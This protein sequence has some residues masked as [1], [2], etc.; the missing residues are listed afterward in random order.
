MGNEEHKTREDVKELPK[1]KKRERL[2]VPYEG[3]EIADTFGPF[4]NE[5]LAQGMAALIAAHEKVGR[6]SGKSQLNQPHPIPAETV[7]AH[8]DLAVLAS[9]E[10][11]QRFMDIQEMP[12]SQVTDEDL[13]I[14]VRMVNLAYDKA[15]PVMATMLPVAQKRMK[16]SLVLLFQT[17][18]HIYEAGL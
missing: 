13:Y 3:T 14:F 10:L 12:P 16:E 1:R 7:K 15:I 17:A 9:G 5:D 18:E 4:S 2:L 6:I 8:P 11:M